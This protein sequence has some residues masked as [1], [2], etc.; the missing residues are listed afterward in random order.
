MSEHTQPAAGG[1]S[2]GATPAADAIRDLLAGRTA[3]V[4]GAD[5]FVGSHLV[6]ALLGFDADVHAVVRPTSS[7]MLTNLAHLQGRIRVHRADLTD[8]HSTLQLLRRMAAAAERPPV[9]FHLAGQ[10]HVGESWDRPYETFATNAIGTLNLLQSIVDLDLEIYRLDTAGSSEEYGNVHPELL[11]AYRFGPDGGLVLD[12]TSP[13]NPQ[14]VYATSKVAADYL[15]RN[16]HAAYGVP[17]LVTRMFNNYGPRQNPRFV[18]GTIITQALSR[19]VIELGYVQARRDFCFVEDGAM[20]H[21][22]AAL[23]GEPGGLYVY[24]YGEHITIEDWCDLI[25]ETG[26]EEGFWDDREL[27][28]DGPRRGRLGCSEVQELRVDYSKLN[29][30]SGWAPAWSWKEGLRRTIHWF[31]E[32]RER[33]IGRVDWL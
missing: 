9:I 16:Y 27:R 29:N 26:R 1:G 20:G 30:L 18:T 5:G 11:E 19:E 15:T 31:A 25:V 12:T 14:S 17:A 21:I 7:G 8:K 2:H 6:E 4:T 33:W 22:H 24:G 32:N 3:L 23:F 13:L 10:S 28:T